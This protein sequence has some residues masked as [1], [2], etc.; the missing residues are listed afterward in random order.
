MTDHPTRRPRLTA[1][2]LK[3]TKPEDKP[4]ELRSD[5]VPGLMLRVE[6]TGTQ[7]YWV[8]IKRNQRHK[9]GN[10]KVLTLQ[11]AEDRARRVLVDPDAYMR[12]KHKA[13]SLESFLDD[14][15]NPWAKAHLKTG[16]SNVVRIKA[17]FGP[18][19]CAQ[20]LDEITPA[21]IEKWRTDRLTKYGKAKGTVNRDI[22]A[23]SS[24]L[25]KAVEWGTI[26]ENPVRKVK[27]LRLSNQKVRFLS[28]DEFGRLLAALKA[29]DALMRAKRASANE[30]RSKRDR[31]TMPA[32]G[33]FADHLTPLV[34]LSLST[35]MRK[36]EVFAMCWEDVDLERKV[37]T[38]RGEVAKSG[39][40]R[41]IPLNRTAIE[42]LDS[43]K[44]ITQREA[45]LVFQGK[46]KDQPLDN[47]SKSWDGLLEDAKI[48][49]FRWHD[50]RHHFASSLV[51]G[52][53]DLNTVRELLGHADLKMTLRYA[54]LA[55][56][57]KAAA[58]EKIAMEGW[59]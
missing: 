14:H 24:V 31:E 5:R 56:E 17:V 45:G 23:L 54:H 50:L 57:H 42:T 44:Q 11:Q 3:N 52:G 25:S 47:V 28:E 59:T 7:T 8:Q 16:P 53:V 12:E 20:R 15:Y 4:F 22:A 10:A 33:V 41:H 55:P 43:W 48:E 58:V 38:V 27:P 18:Q 32:V 49:N 1:T 19:F 34:L 46:V 39:K 26:T 36:G 35:G 13:D 2:T 21:K 29:R 40:T 51:M 6:P 37:V 9:L 30:W